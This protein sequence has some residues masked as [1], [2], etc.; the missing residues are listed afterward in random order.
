[1]PHC[2]GQICG[3]DAEQFLPW[4]EGI[5]VFGR[6]RA[7]GRYAFDVGKQQTT[8]GQR[9]YALNVAQPKGRPGQAR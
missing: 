9:N 1:M 7:R 3:P 5:F 6:E 8:G 2:G 4:V